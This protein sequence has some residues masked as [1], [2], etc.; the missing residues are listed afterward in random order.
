MPFPKAT[1]GLVMFSN[2]AA[3]GEGSSILQ[4]QPNSFLKSRLWRAPYEDQDDANHPEDQASSIENDC[5]H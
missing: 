3:V 2:S 5:R 4:P 1:N